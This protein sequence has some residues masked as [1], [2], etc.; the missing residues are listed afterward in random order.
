M[1]LFRNSVLAATIAFCGLTACSEAPSPGEPPAS[2]D[3]AANV[4]AAE[5]IAAT[6]PVGNDPAELDRQLADLGW[7]GAAAT[8]YAYAQACDAD[9]ARLEGFKAAQRDQA[10]Q[11]GS[12]AASFDQA[13]AAALPLA[14][15][16]VEIDDLSMSPANRAETCQTMMQSL[17]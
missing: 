17:Q 13:F 16:R 3:A 10:S 5:T 15:R 6:V 4:P 2:P 12:D 7:G 14:T 1:P 9:Q 11:M 8:T